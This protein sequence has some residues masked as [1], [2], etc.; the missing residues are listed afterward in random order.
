MIGLLL[1]MSALG[2]DPPVR[3]G[4]ATPVKDQCPEAMGMRAGHVATCTGVLL[5]TSWA[6]DYELIA[7]H[8]NY[9]ENLYRI[10]T[11]QLE[12]ELQYTNRLLEHAQKPVPLHERPA[13]WGGIG[14]IIGGA[15][16]VG[17]GYAVVGASK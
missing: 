11:L 9:V 4:P 7:A 10:D 3:P 14:V 16:V 13:F 8:L 6:A 1:C 2:A 15:A 5:P 17:G 12:Q